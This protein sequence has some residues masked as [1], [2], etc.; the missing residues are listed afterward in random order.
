M[1]SRLSAQDFWKSKEK[2]AKR[3]PSPRGA[4]LRAT[5]VNEMILLHQM[6]KLHVNCKV[7]YL[8]YKK[9]PGKHTVNFKMGSLIH[10]TELILT[11]IYKKEYIGKCTCSYPLAC[12]VKRKLEQLECYSKELFQMFL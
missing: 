8:Y 3:Y 1:L 4:T 12:Y 11:W 10:Y 2:T 6:D 7:T 9:I 5:L